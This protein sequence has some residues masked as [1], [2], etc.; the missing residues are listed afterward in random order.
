[1]KRTGTTNIQKLM[2]F[3]FIAVL[4]IVSGCQGPF[5][6]STALGLDLKKLTVIPNGITM[7]TS[8]SQDFTAVD[9][10]GPFTWSVYS[11]PGSFPA[12]TNTATETFNSGVVAGITTIYVRD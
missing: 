3:G 8:S 12:P 10:T 11:G 1:M 2:V 7:S 4:L 6:L 5:N 9:G